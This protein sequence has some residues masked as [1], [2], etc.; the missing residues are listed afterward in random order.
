VA[1]G[2]KKDVTMEMLKFNA[3]GVARLI[4]HT[5]K[6]KTHRLSFGETKAEPA[7]WLIGDSGVYLMS[8]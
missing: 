8:N 6:A 4:A 1:L 2:F 5:R 3:A 7:L